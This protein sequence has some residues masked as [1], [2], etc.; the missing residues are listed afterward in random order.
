MTSDR[1]FHGLREGDLV[2]DRGDTQYVCRES[3]R[4]VKAKILFASD[5]KGVSTYLHVWST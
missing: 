5:K 2:V 4:K 1:F 3:C